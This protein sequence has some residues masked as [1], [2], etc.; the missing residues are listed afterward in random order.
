MR[1][2]LGVRNVRGG[3][4]KNGPESARVQ[5]GMVGNGES[6]TKSILDS[7]Q[8][9]MA[10]TFANH[11][12]SETLKNGDDLMPRQAAQLRHSKE[13]IAGS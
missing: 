2:Q 3:V 10:S 8:F 7:A 9:H 6:L 13:L 12:E 1:H 4:T 5:L 11:L